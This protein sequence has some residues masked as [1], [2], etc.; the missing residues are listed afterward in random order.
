VRAVSVLA[1]WT[2]PASGHAQSVTCAPCGIVRTDIAALDAAAKPDLEPKQWASVVRLSD[3]RFLVAPVAEEGTIAEFSRDGHILRGIGRRG[4]GPQEFMPIAGVVP[5]GAGGVAVFERGSRRLTMLTS[6]GSIRS[7]VAIPFSPAATEVLKVR[8]LWLIAATSR[9]PEYAGAYFH[10][11]DAFGVVKRSFGWGGPMEATRFNGSVPI[12]RA[13]APRSSGG[14]WSVLIT[15]GQADVLE[16][17][18]VNGKLVRRV[19]L[20]R[21]WAPSTSSVPSRMLD[22]RAATIAVQEQPDGSLWVTTHVLKERR[23]SGGASNER[24]LPADL[25]EAYRTIVR[26]F[27]PRAGRLLASIELDAHVMTSAVGSMWWYTRER[28]SGEPVT[29]VFRLSLKRR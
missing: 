7:R 22:R 24:G 10:L 27:D 12:R 15:Y 29:Q 23:Q 21:D 17:W 4:M 5:D 20:A 1:L 25:N 6:D 16:E 26:A 11:T 14:H 19:D 13:V 9:L 28:P 18:D 3:G 8:G 2:A